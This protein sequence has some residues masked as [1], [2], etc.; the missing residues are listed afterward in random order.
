MVKIIG[1]KRTPLILIHM[2]NGLMQYLKKTYIFS[3]LFGG[4]LT[5]ENEKI[6]AI[7]TPLVFIND[8]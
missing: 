2:K 6:N 7:F 1:D 4:D 3:H 8:P 5:I